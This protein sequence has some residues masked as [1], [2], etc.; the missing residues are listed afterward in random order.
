LDNF[1]NKRG[2]EILEH[3]QISDSLADSEK[4]DLE[5]IS[6][7]KKHEGEKRKYERRNPLTAEL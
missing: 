1:A 3:L 4:N 5:L 2:K 6:S 7:K